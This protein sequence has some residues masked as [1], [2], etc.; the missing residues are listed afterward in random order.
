M[1]PK[2]LIENAKASNS[3]GTLMQIW[4]SASIFVFIWKKYDE[5]FIIKTL[6]LF[7]ISENTR[8]KGK[9]FLQTFR[10]NKM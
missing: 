6:L 4:R 8:D 5:N 7:E 10:N 1:F 2:C 3:K 9:V